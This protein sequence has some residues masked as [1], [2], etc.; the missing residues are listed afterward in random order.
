MRSISIP[1]IVWVPVA[2]IA[3]VSLTIYMMI[4]DNFSKFLHKY[5]DF[6]M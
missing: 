5:T 6:Y 3:I 4:G 1:A 2:I